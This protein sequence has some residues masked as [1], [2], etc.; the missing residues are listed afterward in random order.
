MDVVYEFSYSMFDKALY[1]ERVVNSRCFVPNLLKYMCA[2]IYLNGKS[3][4]KVIAKTKWCKF[5]GTQCM[6]VYDSLKF[7]SDASALSWNLAFSQIF[8]P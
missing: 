8:L 5:C 6:Y 1:R 7:F 2:K 4:G 3:F